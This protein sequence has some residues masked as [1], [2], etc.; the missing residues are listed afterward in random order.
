M[1]S[2]AHVGLILCGLAALAQA[3]PDAN[4]E[5]AVAEVLKAGG[6]VKRAAKLPGKPIIGV[7]LTACTISESGLEQLRFLTDLQTLDL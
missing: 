7:E 6:S 3:Q 1:R 4:Q 2:R 5:R